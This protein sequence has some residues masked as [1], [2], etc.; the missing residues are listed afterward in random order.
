MLLGLF[1]VKDVKSSA[2][3]H[4]NHVPR[5]NV[6]R[7]GHKALVRAFAFTEC[8]GRNLHIVRCRLGI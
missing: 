8:R 7:E 6:E 5:G 2:L 1:K 3:R 4:F